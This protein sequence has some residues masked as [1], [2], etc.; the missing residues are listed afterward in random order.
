M[1]NKVFIALFDGAVFHEEN[2]E[3]IFESSFSIK[4]Q[5]F[6]AFAYTYHYL[7]WFSKVHIIAWHK[8]NKLRLGLAVLFWLVALGIYF[9]D[10][11]TGILTLYFLST[12]HVLMEFP[13]NIESIHILIKK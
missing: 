7:N 9:Y 6:V 4:I 13:L 1:L 11:K 10:F 8:V 2:K 5:R 12:L 3:L